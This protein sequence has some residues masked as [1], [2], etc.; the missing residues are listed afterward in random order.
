VSD[1][2]YPHQIQKSRD[3]RNYLT[4]RFV[5]AHHSCHPHGVRN[6]VHPFAAVRMI[7]R[8]DGRS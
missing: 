8:R 3:A 7:K 2:S 5:S 4:S 6:W 1:H